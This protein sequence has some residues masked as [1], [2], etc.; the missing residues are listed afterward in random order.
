MMEIMAYFHENGGKSLPNAMKKGFAAAFDKF[1]AYQLAKYRGENK[2]VKLV[3]LVNLVHP[4]PNEKNA[5]ALKALVAGE[6][7]STGTWEAKLTQAGQKA[8]SELEKK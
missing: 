1:D 2:S 7:K 3:D 5:D 8:G 6:L 4:F